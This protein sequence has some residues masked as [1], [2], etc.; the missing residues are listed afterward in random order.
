MSTNQPQSSS[1]N[2]N[3]MTILVIALLISNVFLLW[4]VHTMNSNKQSTP[5]NQPGV[6]HGSNPAPNNPSAP[7]NGKATNSS[8]N[9]TN[10]DFDRLYATVLPKL[11]APSNLKKR[12]VIT[13]IPQEALYILRNTPGVVFLDVRTIEEFKT[14][15]APLALNFPLYS[16]DPKSG[17]YVLYKPFIKN[18]KSKVDAKE[19][20]FKTPIILIDSNGARSAQ[21]GAILQGKGFQEVYVTAGGYDGFNENSNQKK[22][23]QIIGPKSLR[24]YTRNFEGVWVVDEKGNS[25]PQVGWKELGFPIITGSTAEEVLSIPGTNNN[26]KK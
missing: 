8:A 23:N 1:K 19:W 2:S 13:I 6:S 3:M 16:L 14:G 15:H 26:G 24:E 7:T 20:T 12:K 25:D 11:Q 17:K 18:L 5:V 10:A 22:E 9:T 21:A 4:N